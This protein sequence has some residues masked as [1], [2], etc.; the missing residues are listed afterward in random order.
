M[1]S[2]YTSK[3]EVPISRVGELKVS[4]SSLRSLCLMAVRERIEPGWKKA[5][6]GTYLKRYLKTKTCE[7]VYNDN[8]RL[9]HSRWAGG[10]IIRGTDRAY[11][12]DGT[13]NVR[14]TIVTNTL[15]CV[16]MWHPNGKRKE[17]YGVRL[18]FGKNSRK[19]FDS[20]CRTVREGIEVP[21]GDALYKIRWD[22]YGKIIEFSNFK[23]NWGLVHRWKE[24]RQGHPELLREETNFETKVQTK[25]YALFKYQSRQERIAGCPR[26]KRG[27]RTVLR[28]VEKRA[29]GDWRPIRVIP[30]NMWALND[31]SYDLRG[32]Q[33]KRKYVARTKGQ[34]R[35]AYLYEDHETWSLRKSE[36]RDNVWCNTKVCYDSSKIEIQRIKVDPNQSYHAR[37]RSRLNVGATFQWNLQLKNP[38]EVRVPEF[39]YS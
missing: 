16:R 38:T 14:E 35:F 37:K 34:R 23:K 15:Y 32:C 8:C 7:C 31:I 5:E 3:T 36:D 25:S 1:Q 22:S 28:T 20:C 13:L 11:Y 17:E 6:I 21:R 9:I 26:R 4:V 2:L 33:V 29:N 24:L 12:D 30:E 18:Y 10:H 19:S 27:Y 39:L